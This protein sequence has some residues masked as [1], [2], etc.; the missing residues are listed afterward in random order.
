MALGSRWLPRWHSIL[1]CSSDSF[2]SH[3]HSHYHFQ[4][5]VSYP[6]MVGVASNHHRYRV[7]TQRC[8]QPVPAS[9]HSICH[10]SQARVFSSTR[11]VVVSNRRHYH[12]QH[13]V[14]PIPAS[15]HLFPHLSQDLPIQCNSTFLPISSSSILRQWDQIQSA[16]LLLQWHYLLVQIDRCL[17]CARIYHN[18]GT[19]H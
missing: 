17:P 1:P 12:S 6:T 2:L 19:S 4:V 16:P 15:R 8:V 5:Q 14:R 13:W 10:Q 3:I 7:L 11:V 9:R 18:C